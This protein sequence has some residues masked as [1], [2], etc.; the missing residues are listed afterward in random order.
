LKNDA[1]SKPQSSLFAMPS[2]PQALNPNR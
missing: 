2:M 1:S